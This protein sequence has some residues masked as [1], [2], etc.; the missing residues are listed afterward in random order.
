MALCPRLPGWAGTREVKPVWILLKQKGGEWQWHQLGYMQL[1]TL[2]Q[3]DNH[4]STPPLSFFYR[5][6]ALPV[7]Q[8]TVSKHWRQNREIIMHTSNKLLSCYWLPSKQTSISGT[9]ALSQLPRTTDSWAI[10]P[11]MTLLHAAS[12]ELREFLLRHQPCMYHMRVQ[13]LILYHITVV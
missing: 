11:Q 8:P 9:K 3:T 1:C 7:T 4:A 12:R 5:P 10:W 13:A 6:D 2:L